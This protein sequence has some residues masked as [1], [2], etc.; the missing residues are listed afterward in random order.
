MQM[1]NENFSVEEL[2]CNESFQ[3]YCLGTSLE[4]QLL[5]QDWIKK[6]PH[7]RAEFEESKR[8]VEILTVKQGSR[9]KQVKE[10]RS[11]VEQRELFSKALSPES[12]TAVS[13]QSPNR[14]P[15]L[16][17]YAAGIAAV[18]L[19]AVFIYF[20]TL[21]A[22]N[23]NLLKQPVG[24][25]FSSGKALRKT[26]VLIDG[27]VITLARES[28]IKLEEG[29]NKNNRALWLSGEAYFDVKHDSKHPFIVRTT[30]NDIKVLGTVFNVKAYSSDKEME[31][32]LIRG[33]VRV[34]SKKYPGKFVILK[35][36]EKLITNNYL[37]KVSTEVQKPF[38]ITM[39][40]MNSETQKPEEV[41]WIQQRLEIENEPLSLIAKKLETWYGIEI[42][43][44][45]EAVKN[46][47]YS[48]V[49]ENET[50]IKTLEALQLSYPFEF[51]VE[52]NKIIINK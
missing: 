32:S 15:L 6:H 39:L 12:Y 40:K 47:H 35:P 34:D 8:L 23:L 52:Q 42:V 25:H 11:G 13:S 36:N 10:L 2:I 30:Y 48:G 16:Y 24:E 4:N 3:H 29:F 1:P 5:W 9:I 38:H 51:K 43:I 33:S 46:Y 17:Q 28:V 26:I 18:V 14:F 49:F 27:S 19:V 50:I 21:P 41:Q 22:V 37:V 20:Y 45:D 7:K 44:K 31:T